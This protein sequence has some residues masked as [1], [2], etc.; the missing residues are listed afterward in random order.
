MIPEYRQD[1]NI[2]P[3]NYQLIDNFIESRNHLRDNSKKQYRRILELFSNYTNKPFVEATLKDLNKFLN[4]IP[5]K[6]RDV[7]HIKNETKNR[8][9]II[10]KQFYKYLQRLGIV[11]IN[12]FCEVT[13]YARTESN[14]TCHDGID[15]SQ[16]LTLEE[17][18]RFLKL[19]N[20]KVKEAEEN[21][22]TVKLVLALRDKA[23]FSIMI[24]LGF[25]IGEMID[26]EINQIN[27][28]TKEISIPPAKSKNHQGRILVLS[29]NLMGILGQ[30]L[31][32]RNVININKSN[33]VFLSKSGQR[34]SSSNTNEKLKKYGAECGIDTSKIHNHA[35]RHTAATF[36]ALNYE[37]HETQ[38][39]LGHSSITTTQKYA[40]SSK[41][42]MAKI[43]KN[44]VLDKL[45]KP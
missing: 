9:L 8:Y 29:E 10:I 43:S 44:P 41:E 23:L 12:P 37:L 6:N 21:K 39:L 17:S 26:L 25:R 27:P 33:Y 42:M 35:L 18:K 16:Y 40:H 38:M 3:E 32:V 45:L 4:M 5:G 2:I 13:L 20:N 11:T 28:Q 30:Y 22:E 7:K 31:K 1:I 14:I 36:H 15:E 19:L 24:N 34:L